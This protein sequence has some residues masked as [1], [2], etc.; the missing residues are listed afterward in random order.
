MSPKRQP[1]P[2]P[3]PDR[4]TTA[5]RV[6]GLGGIVLSAIFWALT[7]RVSPELVGVFA[8]LWGFTEGAAALKELGRR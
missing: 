5:G 2:P 8:S 4:I 7:N 1:A 6:V 3:P